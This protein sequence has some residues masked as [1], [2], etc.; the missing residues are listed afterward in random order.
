MSLRLGFYRCW[1]LNFIADCYIPEREDWPKE[2]LLVSHR[3]LILYQKHL[4]LQ[5]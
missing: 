5:C 3:Q 4:E 1:T 2:K